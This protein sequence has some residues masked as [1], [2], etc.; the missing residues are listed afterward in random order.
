MSANAL[1]QPLILQPGEGRSYPCGP[2]TALF[3]ADGPETDSRYSI[4]EWWLD[5]NSDGPGAHLRD[6][7]DEIFFVIA[8]RPSV[9][10]GETWH[11]LGV[12][13]LLVIPAGVMHDFANR[14]DDRAGLLNVWIPGGFEQNMPSIVDWF[15]ANT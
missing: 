10:V 5:P 14:T 4:S 12:G 1:R 15:A 3:K 13:S 9:L 8:G 11:E 7:N 6:A 2:M